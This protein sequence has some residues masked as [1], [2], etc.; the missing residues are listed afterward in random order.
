MIKLI[1]LQHNRIFLRIN[2]LERVIKV[3]YQ[4]KLCTSI[5]FIRGN[6]WL[7][8]SL[9]SSLRRLEYYKPTILI[10]TNSLHL[11]NHF[12]FNTPVCVLLMYW[13]S[14]FRQ[15][16][17]ENSKKEKSYLCTCREPGRGGLIHES[18]KS[19]HFIG[20]CSHDKACF[21]IRFDSKRSLTRKLQIVSK[22]KKRKEEDKKDTRLT[23]DAFL[24]PSYSFTDPKGD[25]AE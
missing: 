7:V 12:W 18:G 8:R 10:K 15:L 19:L 3:I 24:S 17:S 23:L 6:T 14:F 25:A 22:P 4:S 1:L 2:L 9:I 20:Q 13:D 11:S 16:N 5:F 21:I